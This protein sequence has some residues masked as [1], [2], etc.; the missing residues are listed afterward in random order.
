M[1]LPVELD[2]SRRAKKM[3]LEEGVIAEEEKAGAS[4]VL[5]AAALTYVAAL[6]TSI[7]YFLRFAT[8]ILSLFGRRRD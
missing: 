3:L 7:L 6:L 8:V 2:A 4:K 5:G 1:T